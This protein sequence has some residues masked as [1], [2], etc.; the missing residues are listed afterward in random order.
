VTGNHVDVI[1]TWNAKRADGSTLEGEYEAT[2]SEG[3]LSG[4]THDVDNPSSHATWT[5]T[6]GPTKRCDETA[7]ALPT[8]S[9]SPLSDYQAESQL[10]SALSTDQLDL[11]GDPQGVIEQALTDGYPTIMYIEGQ[12]GRL[13]GALSA[14]VRLGAGLVQQKTAGGALAFPSVAAAMPIILRMAY[15]AA[16]ARDKDV[17]N[18]LSTAT[19]RLLALLI[20]QDT[21]AVKGAAG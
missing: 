12:V 6:G 13:P 15:D 5:A 18:S 2:I 11:S 16:D 10:L 7:N 1:V 20:T 9:A 14:I 19:T 17:Q 8:P 4:S 3:A 21:Y